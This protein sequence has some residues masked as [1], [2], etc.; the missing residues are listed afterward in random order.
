MLCDSTQQGLEM[1][2]LKLDNTELFNGVG[3]KKYI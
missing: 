1:G 2:E 3:G